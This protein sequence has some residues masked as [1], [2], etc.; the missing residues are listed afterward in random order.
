MTP[1][2]HQRAVDALSKYNHLENEANSLRRF[3]VNVCGEREQRM[4]ISFIGVT[5]HID[6][7]VGLDKAIR[8]CCTAWI[9]SG[10]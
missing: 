4:A 6:V 7:P 3:M 1:E 2:Q 8:D 10:C 9:D 5:L